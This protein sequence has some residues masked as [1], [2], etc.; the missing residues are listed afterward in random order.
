[1]ASVLQ[2]DVPTHSSDTTYSL[3]PGLNQ[4]YDINLGSLSGVVNSDCTISFSGSASVAIP[5]Y[6]LSPAVQSRALEGS[7]AKQ[8]NGKQGSVICGP[9]LGAGP[10]AF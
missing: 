9:G 7:E 1:M 5:S 10:T 4:A 2:V 3:T 6:S 8:V